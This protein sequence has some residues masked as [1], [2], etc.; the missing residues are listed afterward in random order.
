M[1]QFTIY[2]EKQTTKNIAGNK[3]LLLLIQIKNEPRTTHLISLW[4]PSICHNANILGTLYD[5]RCTTLI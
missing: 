1:D 3:M 5:L 2:Q 4:H